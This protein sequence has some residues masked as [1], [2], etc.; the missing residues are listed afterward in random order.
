MV[1]ITAKELE[2]QKAA[3]YKLGSSEAAKTLAPEFVELEK[4]IWTLTKSLQE[5]EVWKEKAQMHEA[6]YLNT[7]SALDQFQFFADETNKATIQKDKAI[8][9]LVTGL[10]E[11]IGSMKTVIAHFIEKD[12]VEIV[13]VQ[14]EPSEPVNESGK[15]FKEYRSEQHGKTDQTSD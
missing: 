15:T 10:I 8:T 1:R 7:K 6:A 9:T 14:V 13:N 4:Q 11:S 3:A 2:R 12:K 5:S